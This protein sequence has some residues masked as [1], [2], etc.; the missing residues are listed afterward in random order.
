M[1]MLVSHS[2]FHILEP[3]TSTISGKKSIMSQ[4]ICD[5]NDSCSS[6]YFG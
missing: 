6:N 4:G 5:Q 1:Q 2:I 3:V